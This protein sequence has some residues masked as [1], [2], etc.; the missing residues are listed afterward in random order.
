MD[1]DL[2]K[3]LEDTIRASRLEGIRNCKMEAA[4]KMLNKGMDENVISEVLKLELGE[5]VDLKVV[6]EF[7]L[8]IAGFREALAFNLQLACAYTNRGL[9]YYKSGQYDLAITDYSKALSHD[10]QLA[11]A[12]FSRGL[13]YYKRGEN[14][15]A[16][17]DYNKALELDPQDPL[18]KI[19]RELVLLSM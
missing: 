18:F 19:T 3:M 5:I 15:L 14:E 2:S 10:P 9:S 4:E 11:Y 16:L 13:S 8:S 7:G 12:Y 17:A 1:M 6:K